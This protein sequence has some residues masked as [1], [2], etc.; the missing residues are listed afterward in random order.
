M[1]SHSLSQAG[2][3]LN[4]SFFAAGASPSARS[5]RAWVLCLRR[6]GLSVLRRPAQR[7]GVPRVICG[8]PSALAPAQRPRV[9]AFWQAR[10][11]G[12]E[13]VPRFR[14]SDACAAPVHHEGVL[15]S[16]SVSSVPSAAL[17]A[18]A[19]APQQFGTLRFVPRLRN[20]CRSPALLAVTA[21]A[22]AHLW[23]TL[24]SS[25]QLPGYALQL[26]LMFNVSRQ[27]HPCEPR[28]QSTSSSV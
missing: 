18:A 15:L 13:P 14:R 19:S 4:A 10:W 6:R 8:A 7:G 21:L 17:Q 3:V 2:C 24:P 9:L 1:K 23:L 28:C 26:P 25:G 22:F 20:T 5:V 12:Q 11:L 27:T 16:C